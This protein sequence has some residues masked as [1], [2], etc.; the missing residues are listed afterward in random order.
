MK[1]FLPEPRHQ[2]VAQ[3]RGAGNVGCAFW[4][5]NWKPLSGAKC[6]IVIRYGYIGTASVPS[7]STC[8]QIYSAPAKKTLPQVIIWRSLYGRGA[9]LVGP[10]EVSSK[11]KALRLLIH[12]LGHRVA[13]S[14]EDRRRSP[15]QSTSNGSRKSASTLPE[16]VIS[17][18][19]EVLI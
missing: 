14:M 11:A 2:G 19:E 10:V 15:P 3:R 18:V 12:A 16:D 13:V 5:L 4:G 8:K 17:P 9:G 7:S 6:S 1:S